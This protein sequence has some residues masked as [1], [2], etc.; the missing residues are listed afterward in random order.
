MT[1]ALPGSG[2]STSAGSTRLAR[3]VPRSL[4]ERS[5][6][7][8]AFGIVRTWAGIALAWWLCGQTPT[9]WVWPLAIVWI[10]TLQYH[11][12]ILGHDGLHFLLSNDRRTN[13]AMCRWALHGPHGA[14][15]G[16]MRSNHLNHHARF[17]S[18]QDLDRQYYDISRFRQRGSLR[19]WL[20]GSLLGTMVLPIAGKLLSAKPATD[21]ASLK[22][23]PERTADLISVVLSQ[24][25]IALATGWITGHWFAYIALWIIPMFTVMMGLNSIRSCLE[26]AVI[27][28]EQPSLITFSS[29]RLERFFLAPFNMNVHAEHHLVPAVPW[30]QLPR[31]RAFLQAHGHFGDVTFCPSYRQRELE[32]S[33]LLA[34]PRPPRAEGLS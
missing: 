22:A 27:D 17:G 9:L 32:L 24:A 31:L 18:A 8:S 23:R 4:F 7:R 28:R 3:L 19:L 13:D 34:G 12:N 20:I 26:H 21:A 1:A 10:G 6:A 33:R 15:L 5:V 14:P 25:W 16:A 2:I 29:G 11:L 30:H